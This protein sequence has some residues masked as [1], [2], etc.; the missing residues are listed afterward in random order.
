[1]VTDLISQEIN[2]LSKLLNASNITKRKS[3]KKESKRVIK[4]HY[5]PP[6]IWLQDSVQKDSSMSTWSMYSHA[7]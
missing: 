3:E 6:N 1:M 4:Y 2:I 5:P 7:R